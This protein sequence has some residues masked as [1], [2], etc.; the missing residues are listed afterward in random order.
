MT[1]GAPIQQL[2]DKDRCWYP[3]CNMRWEILIIGTRRTGKF[4]AIHHGLLKQEA[5]EYECS[6]YACPKCGYHP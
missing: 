6:K 3:E 1:E 2:E 4:C 5:E